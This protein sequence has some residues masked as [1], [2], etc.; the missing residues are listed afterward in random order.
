MLKDV[1][2]DLKDET[3]KGTTVD[4]SVSGAAI[5]GPRAAP[6]GRMKIQLQL[7]EEEETTFEVDGVVVREFQSDGGSLWGVAF[8]GLDQETKERLRQ[9]VEQ[10]ADAG[11]EQES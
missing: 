11:D 2:I 6:H 4:V 7:D 1:T 3:V 5:W 10:H 9:F 8:T